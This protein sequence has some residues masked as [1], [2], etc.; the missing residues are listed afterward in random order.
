MQ[1]QHFTIGT[2]LRL[3]FGLVLLITALITALGLWRLHDLAQF[4][5]QLATTEKTRLQ[6]AMQWRQAIALNWVRARAALFE[7][8]PARIALWEAEMDATSQETAGARKALQALETSADGKQLVQAIDSARDAFRSKRAELLKRKAAGED[9]SARIDTEIKPLAEA[10]IQKLV[11]L[12]QRQQTLYEQAHAQAMA[13]AAQSRTLLLAAALAA[14]LLGMG[15]AAVI[16]RSITSALRQAMQRT[17]RIAQG[18]LSQPL[19][20]QGHDEVA[21]LLRTLHSMQTSLAGVVADVRLNADSVATASTEI[22]LGNQDL[23]QRT[24]QQASAL[25]QTAA[26][27][28]ELGATVRQNADNAAQ[29][30]QLAA[31]A[32]AVAAQG[33]QV[34]GEVVQTMSGIHEASR[35]IADIIQV[36]ASIAFQTNILALNAAVEAAR[37]GEQGRGFAVVASEV[38][39][40]AQRSGDAARE[41][42]QLITDSVQR[43]EQGTQLADRAGTTMGEV[44]GA[45]GRVTDIMGEI[46]AASREQADGVAQVSEAVSHMDKSTQQNAALVEQSAAAAAH[47]QA[48]SAQLVQA[49]AVFQLDPGQTSATPARGGAPARRLAAT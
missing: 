44:V 49:M 27:M 6:S 13:R 45:I 10:F 43:V 2:R 37:A 33:G 26:S 9:I 28:E 39:H 22:A 23:S 17:E 31:S 48:Q 25:E 32:S 38:R 14:L 16:G 5:E 3:G 19:Q 35:K 24:E 1:L 21:Q 34:V 36:I 40:L 46:S 47:L 18:D 20:A 12:Q 42:R 8:D 30:N 4:T 15:A 11:Q 7:H 41:I 29:A